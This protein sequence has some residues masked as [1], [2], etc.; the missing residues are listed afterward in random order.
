MGM[1]LCMALL[2]GQA[3]AEQHIHL[4]DEASATCTVCAH[5]L[6]HDGATA[7]GKALAAEDIGTRSYVPTLQ[8]RDSSRPQR[9]FLS[10]APPSS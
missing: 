5:T 8:S 6:D 9:F 10:R 3:F 2:A 4:N 1:L 7:A